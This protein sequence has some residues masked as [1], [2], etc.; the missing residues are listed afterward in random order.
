MKFLCICIYNIFI[1]WCV[2]VPT[3][4]FYINNFI[5]P[6]FEIT[7]ESWLHYIT[8]YRNAVSLKSVFLPMLNTNLNLSLVGE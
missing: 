2:S 8:L 5:T 3:A 1:F 4:I 6:F 7:P